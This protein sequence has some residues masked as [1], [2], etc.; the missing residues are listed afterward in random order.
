MAAYGIPISPALT[1]T[2]RLRAWW[3]HTVWGYT[4]LET[5]RHPRAGWFGRIAYEDT[6]LLL[7]RISEHRH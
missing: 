3:L 4:I 1:T 6:Y 2:S 5:H 7:P